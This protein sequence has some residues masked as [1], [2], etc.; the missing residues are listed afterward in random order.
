MSIRLYVSTICFVAAGIAFGALAL[1]AQAQASP[2]RE[3][4][5]VLPDSQSTKTLESPGVLLT[6][7]GT[8]GAVEREPEAQVSTAGDASLWA[9]FA[10]NGQCVPLLDTLACGASCHLSPDSMWL[11]YL[12]VT[13]RAYNR[14]RLNGSERQT[15]VENTGDLQWYSQDTYVLWTPGH[16]TYLLQSDGARTPLAAGGLVSIQPEGGWALSIVAGDS[17]DAPALRHLVRVLPDDA[18]ADPIVLGVDEPFFNNSA[19]SAAGDFAYVAPVPTDDGPTAELYWL[20]MSAAPPQPA[21][22]TDL[23]S[24]YGRVRIDGLAN[25][26]LA[27]SPEGTRIAFWVTPLD[28]TGSTRNQHARL[29]IVDVATGALTALCEPALVDHTPQTPNLVWSPDGRYV[30]FAGNLP[31]PPIIYT[32]FAYDTQTEELLRLHENVYAYNG[33]AD[34]YGWGL[35]PGTNPG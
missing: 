11:T 17:P 4:C 16:R 15:L 1:P 2:V 33:R 31:D 35:L 13:T 8:A 3:V 34:V 9:C 27:W 22:L 25:G 32:L 20:D 10:S 29:H 18:A 5:P 28:R 6:S 23:A 7:F 19:W 24:L 26:N 14:M 21:R 12:N 30:A